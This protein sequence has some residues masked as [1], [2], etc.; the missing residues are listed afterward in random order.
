MVWFQ[1]FSNWIMK[2]NCSEVPWKV[3]TKQVKGWTVEN[4]NSY[5]SMAVSE[6]F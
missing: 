1:K 3:D 6:T 4:R 2:Q 5:Q